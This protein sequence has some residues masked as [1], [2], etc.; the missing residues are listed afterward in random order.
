MQSEAPNVIELTLSVLFSTA[1]CHLLWLSPVCALCMSTRCKPL[2]LEIF[3]QVANCFM[4]PLIVKS[5]ESSSD[6]DIT[7][8]YWSGPIPLVRVDWSTATSSKI[9]G[10]FLVRFYGFA[11]IKCDHSVH[12]PTFFALDHV[13]EKS[14]TCNLGR[15]LFDDSDPE[16]AASRNKQ[17]TISRQFQVHLQIPLRFTMQDEIRFLPIYSQ[18]GDATSISTRSS[19]YS[20]ELEDV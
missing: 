5:E 1:N 7:A 16:Q 3:L 19:P 14:L 2:F 10:T 12:V 17:S 20:A 8:R 6:F 11:R 15:T 9:N 4:Y 18:V 13:E